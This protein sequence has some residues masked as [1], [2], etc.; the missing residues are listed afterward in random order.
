DRRQVAGQDGVLPKRQPRLDV[1]AGV[2]GSIGRAQA[3]ERHR[4]AK[5]AGNLAS[6]IIERDLGMDVGEL[7]VELVDFDRGVEQEQHL[8]RFI[9]AWRR[10]SEMLLQR[11]LL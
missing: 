7:V 1:V 6:H 11:L 5:H 10:R 2:L 9:L 3:K 8:S 4:Y